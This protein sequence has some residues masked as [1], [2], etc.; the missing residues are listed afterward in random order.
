MGTWGPEH[1]RISTPGHPLHLG[2]CTPGHQGTS[3]LAWLGTWA[4]PV[5]HQD[6]CV[7]MILDMLTI[8]AN[9][10]LFHVISI[11]LLCN[12]GKLINFF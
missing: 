1:L 7:A 8:T 9:H 3:V 11:M 5:M 10:Y 6:Q 12:N 4:L 2:A